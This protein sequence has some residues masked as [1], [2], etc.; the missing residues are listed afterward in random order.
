[1]EGVAP[2]PHPQEIETQF[3]LIVRESSMGSTIR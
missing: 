3:A 2:R 1:I